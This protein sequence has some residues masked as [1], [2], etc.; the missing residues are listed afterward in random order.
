M[1]AAILRHWGHLLPTLS[2]SKAT[3]IVIDLEAAIEQGKKVKKEIPDVVKIEDDDE[4]GQE[5]SE[6][7][8]LPAPPN[9]LEEVEARIAYLKSLPRIAFKF[10]CLL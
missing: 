4:E 10:L 3:V 1:F 5:M 7:M 9:T 2:P 8:A 6:F